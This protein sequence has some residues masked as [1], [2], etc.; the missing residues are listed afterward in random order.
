[1]KQ[2]KRRSAMRVLWLCIAVLALCA[3]V[4]LGVLL[5]VPKSQDVQIPGARGTV[6][7]TVQMPSKLARAGDVPLAVLCHGMTCNQGG[8]S[9]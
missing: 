7:A 6:P 1:M 9:Q 5:P 4:A 3:A 2:Y 8:G